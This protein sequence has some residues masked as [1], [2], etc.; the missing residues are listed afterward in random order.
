MDKKNLRTGVFAALTA[1]LIGSAWQLV[2]RHGVT[3]TLGPMELVLLRYGIPALLLSPLWLGK[4]LVPPKASRL[5][6]VLLV[7]G[8]GL[9]FGLL[10]LAGA[11]WAPASHMG[12]FM[13]G[14]LPL[15]TAI[16]A[17]LH[18]GQ[19]VGG[20][21][22]LGL[23]CIAVGIALFATDSLRDG[24][25]DWRGDLLFLSAAVL[26]AV[27]SLAF[28]HCDFTPWQGTAF[29][30]GWSTLLLLPLLGTVGA[31]R[32]L[33]APWTDVAI[34]AVMQGVVAGLLGLMVYMLAVARL[35]AARASLSAALVPV[36]TTLGAAACMNEP[37][38]GEVLLALALVV[39]G[40]VLASGAVRWRAQET[41]QRP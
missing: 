16:G 6:L 10:V 30:N 15:F 31:P 41:Q 25:L 19:K 20:I 1:A 13:A 5:A 38:T 29:V 7:I 14:S 27:H 34:Q 24:S 39:P 35:S 8:G 4:G 22:L 28:A 12:I 36:L 40:I 3:T 2:S 32:L 21:R 26:W 37:I 33:T 23:G 18:K 17:R 9:P 11:R